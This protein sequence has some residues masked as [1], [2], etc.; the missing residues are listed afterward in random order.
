[1]MR[2]ATLVAHPRN[3]TGITLITSQA[4]MH[5]NSTRNQPHWFGNSSVTEAPASMVEARPPLTHSDW[6]GVTLII[7]DNVFPSG[8][9]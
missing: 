8:I 3:L 4:S 6:L 1:M 5:R 7:S 9:M 2:N